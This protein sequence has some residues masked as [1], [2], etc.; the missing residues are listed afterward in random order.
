M[1]PEPTIHDYVVDRTAR[2][3]SEGKPFIGLVVYDKV[4]RVTGPFVDDEA[5]AD[6]ERALLA[7]QAAAPTD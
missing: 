2:G 1:K 5:G 7:A 3:E 4:L 6:F